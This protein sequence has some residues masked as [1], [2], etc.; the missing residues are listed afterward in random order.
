MS[1]LCK[2]GVPVLE[3]CLACRAEQVLLGASAEVTILRAKLAIAIEEFGPAVRWLEAI[4]RRHK[5]ERLEDVNWLHLDE[6]IALAN[7]ALARIDELEEQHGK[8]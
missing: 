5:Q 1:N 2:H 7:A 3:P 4:A 6:M 8:T